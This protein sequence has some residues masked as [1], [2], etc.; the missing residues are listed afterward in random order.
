VQSH[1]F[2]LITAGQHSAAGLFFHGLQLSDC[3]FL[4]VST[5]A[6]GAEWLCDASVMSL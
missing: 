1:L 3:Q 2:G 5:D 6:T 4:F